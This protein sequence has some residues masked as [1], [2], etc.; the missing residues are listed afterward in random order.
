MDLT[1]FQDKLNKQGWVFFPTVLD[2]ATIELLNT[3]LEKAYRIC[4]SIQQKNGI[5]ETTDGTAHHILG[6]ANSFLDFLEPLPL[7][8][9][10]YQFF[11]GNFILNSYGGIINIKD[12]ASYVTNIHRDIRFFSGELPLMLNMLVLLDDFTLENGATYLLSGSHRN[13]ERPSEQDF[14]TNSAR[15]TGKAG[16]I[17]LFNSNLWHAAGHNHTDSVRKGLTLTFTKPFMKQQLDYPRTMGYY[18]GAKLSENQR[19]IIGYNARIPATLEEWYQPPE[20]RMYRPGQ[21]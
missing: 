15:L 2:A 17:L 16:S 7:A 21:D 19:Q 14:F 4:R 13:A 18:N 12:K 3:D 5:T 1:Q 6:L 8:N 11:Q 20:K 10:L 9:Y